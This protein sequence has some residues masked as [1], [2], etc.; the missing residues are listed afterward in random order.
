MSSY[1]NLLLW[2]SFNA[3]FRPSFRYAGSSIVTVRFRP[4]ARIAG[5]CGLAA[6]ASTSSAQSGF[7]ADRS[8]DYFGYYMPA[9]RV[10]LGPWRLHDLF[11]GAP[12]IS[13]PSKTADRPRPSD[14]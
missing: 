3:A 8:R 2:Q 10:Q 6:F 9:G 5:I 14:P 1:A 13:E 11:I 4:L 7:V 12:T